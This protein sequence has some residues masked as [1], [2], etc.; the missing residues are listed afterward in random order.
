MTKEQKWLNTITDF[1][2]STSWMLEKYGGYC[3]SP[4]HFD[5]H[6]CIG[7]KAKRKVNFIS[8]PVGHWYVL[9]VPFEL[10]DVHS[11]SKLNV[12]HCKKAFEATIGTQKALFV[13]MVDSMRDL[14]YSIPFDNDVVAAL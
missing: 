1:A 2:I 10:H 14:G 6:H 11:N 8:T 13:D 9:P 5:R 3:E 12:T 7:R 4:Y